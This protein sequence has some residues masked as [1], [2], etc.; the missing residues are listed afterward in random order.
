MNKV[1]NTSKITIG[2]D[3]EF[4]I[5]DQE[6]NA[7]PSTEL[8]KG[9]KAE[10]EDQGGGYAILKDNVLIEGNIPPASTREQ[11]IQYMKTLKEMI[12]ALLNLRGLRIHSADSMEYERKHLEHP[13]A[14]EFGCSA[15]K[16]GWQLG[17]F[18]AEDMSYM[19]IRVAG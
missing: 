15:Y 8:L 12:S 4:F 17:S 2:S 9:T 18:S 5:V 11:F 14:N 19:P 6:R 1:I 10:P 7:F 16:N 13:E 3:P